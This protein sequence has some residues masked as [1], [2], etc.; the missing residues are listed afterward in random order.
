MSEHRAG[1]IVLLSVIAFVLLTGFYWNEARKEVIFLCGNFT[2]GVSEKSV[3]KQLD[4][5][6]LLNYRSEENSSGSRIE[7][8]STLNFGSPQCTISIDMKGKVI[9]AN[10]E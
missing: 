2:K 9:E 10:L 5:G 4:T 8:N 3:R 6:N 1:I 7:A